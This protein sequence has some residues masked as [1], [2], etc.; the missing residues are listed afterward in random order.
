MALIFFNGEQK[1]SSRSGGKSC[2]YYRNT[3]G[4]AEAKSK[5]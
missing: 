5:L 1:L 3:G 2:A 4:M